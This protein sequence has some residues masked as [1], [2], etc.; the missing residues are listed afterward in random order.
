MN[1][2]ESLLPELKHGD[3]LPPSSA[4][5][6]TDRYTR[7]DMTRAAS[8]TSPGPASDGL[9][10]LTLDELLDYPFQEREVILE[11]WLTTQ[12]L[13][14]IHA[15]RGVGKTHVALNLAVAVATGGTF[16]NW[17]AP[18]PRRVLYLDGEMPGAALQDRAKMILG[19]RK[20]EMDLTHLRIVTPD[21]QPGSMPDL[22]TRA[23][24]AV[25]EEVAMDVDLIIVDNI[26]T[27]CRATGP[28]NDAESWRAP[29]EWGLSMRRA[30]KSVLFIHHSGKRGTQRGSSKR[31]DILDVVLNLT[32]PHDYSPDQGARF[33]IH[34]EKFRHAVG[35]EAR[36]IEARLGTSN[37]GEAQWRWDYVRQPSTDEIVRLFGAGLTQDEIARRVQKDKSTVSRALTKARAEGRLS[38]ALGPSGPDQV[39]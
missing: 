38:G 16:L 29:Q 3:A 18:T 37:D 27:L 19:D 15:W 12:S 2:N 24:Q 23:G 28:E 20:G 9:K 6:S 11:P 21:A 32:Q 22:V 33:E 7:T 8:Y 10:V 14:M 34:Y 31:E 35:N 30:G 36:A 1:A 17:S 13:S 4:V 39:Q 5:A 25:V 26:S